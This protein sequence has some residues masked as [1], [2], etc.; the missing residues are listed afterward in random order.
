MI[1]VLLVQKQMLAREG[2]RLLIEREPDM[3]VV[4]E[5][6]TADDTLIQARGAEPDVVL[7]DMDTPGLDCI[8]LVKRI[9]EEKPDVRVVVM[10]ATCSDE[11]IA[12]ALEQQILGFT[13]KD[14]GFADVRDAIRQAHQG[15]YHYT[16]R[17]MDRVV[18]EGEQPTAGEPSKTRLQILTPRE[19]QLLRLLATGM[20]LKKACVSLHVS[21]KTAD[22]H[23]VNLMK[24]LNIHD[25]VELARFA[26]REKIIEA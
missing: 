6:S 19:M 14:E 25:R 3:S 15:E 26:I 7:M 24:K 12:M 11:S 22:K 18:T 8:E 5:A 2:L 23:K 13:L 9:R 21:Y 4:G 1:R 17:A 20:S 16:R 10:S